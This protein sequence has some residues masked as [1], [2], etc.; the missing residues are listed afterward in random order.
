MNRQLRLQEGVRVY[1][2]FTRHVHRRLL[3]SRSF[4]HDHQLH[5]VPPLDGDFNP[6]PSGE[7]N[8]ELNGG[9]KLR[10]CRDYFACCAIVFSASSENSSFDNW[11]APSW[12]TSVGRNWMNDKQLF[13]LKLRITGYAKHVMY[14]RHMKFLHA[15]MYYIQRTLESAILAS[16][17]YRDVVQKLSRTYNGHRYRPPR[18]GSEAGRRTAYFA[19]PSTRYRPRLVVLFALRRSFRAPFPSVEK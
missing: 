7:S 15:S 18:A 19:A 3:S 2:W 9:E 16:N 13:S 11:T 4:L 8:N 6:V 1:A 12:P 17:K 5:H 14:T 10:N